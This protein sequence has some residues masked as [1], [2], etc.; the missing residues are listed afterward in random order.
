MTNEDLSG[1]ADQGVTL[2]FST[3][4]HQD[5]TQLMTILRVSMTLLILKSD[6]IANQLPTIN[7]QRQDLT[8]LDRHSQILSR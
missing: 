5:I 7:L 2:P 1:E 8:S 6:A 4:A 3:K